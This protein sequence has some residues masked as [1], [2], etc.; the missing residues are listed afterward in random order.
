MSDKQAY[1]QDVSFMNI[2]KLTAKLKK[3]RRIQIKCNKCF[4]LF[5]V[6]PKKRQIPTCRKCFSVNSNDSIKVNI[7]DIVEI[8]SPQKKSIKNKSNNL[9]LNSVKE[10]SI[11]NNDLVDKVKSDITL[12]VPKLK[13]VIKPPF[14]PKESSHESDNLSLPTKKL[15]LNNNIRKRS[16]T[17]ENLSM[18]SSECDADSSLK[19]ENYFEPRRTQ[20]KNESTQNNAFVLSS[21]SEV[22][23]TAVENNNVSHC[24]GSISSDSDQDSTIHNAVSLKCDSPAHSDCNEHLYSNLTD[25]EKSLITWEQDPNGGGRVLHVYQD[26]VDRI[27]Q[28]EDY[29]L[30][31]VQKFIDILFHE[32]Q[33]SVSNY[34]IGI[35]HN[36]AKFLPNIFDYLLQQNSKMQVKMGLLTSKEI[37]TLDFGEFLSNCY[38]TYTDGTYSC[39][40]LHPINIAGKINEE[41]GGY[42]TNLLDIMETSMFLKLI[43]PW[44]KLT[45]QSHMQRYQTHDGPIL[46]SR[47]GEQYISTSDYARNTNK[48][49]ILHSMDFNVLPRHISKREIMI[50]DRTFPH[51]DFIIQGS[52]NQKTTAACGLLQAVNPHRSTSN[53]RLFV[54]DVVCFN[55]KTFDQLIKDLDIDPYEPP[56][57]QVRLVVFSKIWANQAKLNQL[58]RYGHEYAQIK[59]YD[60][61]IYFIP[62]NVIHQFKSVSA[63]ISIAWHTRLKKYNI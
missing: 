59:L 58:R 62:R 34:V 49:N 42:F 5:K 46:W 16:E 1:I 54:K 39:G 22:S 24:L 26:A 8:K 57:T 63:V 20:P 31:I 48:K 33:P 13:L 6:E 23:N 4:Q 30:N 56:A 55:G 12:K 3:N 43:M 45:S 9:N 60:N 51:A 17:I 10:P 36:G 29:K 28:D 52:I 15:K 38:D 11:V 2:C 27:Y 25:R 21:D 40:N 47:C 19:T 32:P 14:T 18:I 50:Y 44:S 7:E 41:T 61:D 35:V 53:N 37:K